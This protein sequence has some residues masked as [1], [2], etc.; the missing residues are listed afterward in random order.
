MYEKQMVYVL[1]VIALM[2]QLT[3]VST[4]YWSDKRAKSRNIHI[5]AHLGLWKSCVTLRGQDNSNNRIELDL[6]EHIPPEQPTVFNEFPKN[7]LYAARAFSLIGLLLI[8]GSLLCMMS[9]NE[10]RKGKHSHYCEMLMLVVGGLCTLL[11]A[12]IW[13]SEMFRIKVT[14]PSDNS[15]HTVKLSPGYSFYVNI[16]GGLSAVGAGLV[17]L[18]SGKQ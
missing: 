12:G 1:A 5:D 15:Q 10:N 2:L 7:T 16:L 17:L 13:A 4:D 9:R 18:S 11:A 6:C 8:F 14:A 3:S